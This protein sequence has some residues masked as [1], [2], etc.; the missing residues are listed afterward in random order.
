MNTTYSSMITRFP[1]SETLLAYLKSAEGGRLSVRENKATPENPFVLIHYDRGVTDMTLPHVEYFRSVVWNIKTNR[2]V[3]AAPSHSQDIA[4]FP[5]DTEFVVEDFVDGVMVNMYWNGT[6]WALSTRTNIDGSSSYFGIL[7]FHELFM[8]TF[9]R[10]GLTLDSFNKNYTYSWVLQHPEERIVVPVRFA[11]I[12]LVEVGIITENGDFTTTKFPID[13]LPPKAQG[14]LPSRHAI[15]TLD[16]VKERVAAWGTRFGTFFQG[17]V[18]KAGGHRWKI[19]SEEYIRARTLRGNTPKR[20]F[21]WLQRFADGSLTEYLRIYP[22]ERAEANVV[23]DRFKLC[24]QELHS[25]YKKIYR[26]RAFPLKEAPHKYRKLLWEIHQARK[27]SYF[28]DLREF[29][30]KQDTARKLW[31]VNYETR[32]AGVPPPPSGEAPPDPYHDFTQA[33]LPSEV[34]ANA[35]GNAVTSETVNPSTDVSVSASA[36]GNTVVDAS[37]TVSDEETERVD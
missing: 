18:I 14:L 1:T 3:C 35:T 23:I 34:S 13:I 16:L 19:R 4:N 2:P 8:E 28:G 21:I 29:M 6:S 26:D 33:S 31:L 36:P 32:Y 7:P 15:E 11:R 20:P 17:L 27:G 22:E 10:A 37:E 5:A 30:N 24:T 25:L 9:F 12:F